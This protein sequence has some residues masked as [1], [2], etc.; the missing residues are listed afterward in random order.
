MTLKHIVR[1]SSINEFFANDHKIFNKGENASL[2]IIK[3]E[4]YGGME[5]N[6]YNVE[7]GMFADFDINCKI[8]STFQINLVKIGDITSATGCFY[9]GIEL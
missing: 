2:M 9:A 8:V 7:E 1:V 4:M 5:D 3:L 6:I